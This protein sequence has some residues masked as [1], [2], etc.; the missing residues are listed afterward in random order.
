MRETLSPNGPCSS[1]APHLPLCS[2][3]EIGGHP[4]EEERPRVYLHIIWSL[5]GKLWLYVG[6]PVSMRERIQKHCDGQYRKRHPSLHYSVWGSDDVVGDS[7]VTM[8]L[9]GASSMSPVTLRRSLSHACFR[10]FGVMVWSGT[11][12]KDFNAIGSHSSLALPLWEGFST[13][14]GEVVTRQTFIEAINSPDSGTSG[15]GGPLEKLL[16]CPS[17]FA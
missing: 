1:I 11:C 16:Q 7:W 10:L 8:S 6:Q 4:E 9:F 15:V 2:T 17:I 5:Q 13:R 3:T 12:L 14:S